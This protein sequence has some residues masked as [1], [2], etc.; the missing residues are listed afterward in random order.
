MN[1]DL[2]YIPETITVHLGSPSSSAENVTVPFAD[3]IKNVA[4]SEIYPTWPVSALRAN[5]LAQI[6]FAL[7]RVYTEYYRSRGYNFD[8]TNS[9]AYDQSYVRDREIFEN[10]GQITDE[11]FDSYIRREGYVEPLFA[12]YCNGTT[13][14]CAGMSQ[15]GSVA[16]AEQGY[17]SLD[18]LRNY[19]G[20]DIEI[21]TDA[22]VRSFYPSAPESPLRLGDTG[23][24]VRTVQLR[25]N[26][27]SSNF[28]T[29][30]KI[31]PVNGF[32][33][34]ATEQAVR[35]FQKLFSLSVDG[36]VGKATWYELE[37]VWAGVKNLNELVSE[38]VIYDDVIKQFS[39]E[40]TGGESGRGVGLLQYYLAFIAE[41]NDFVTAPPFSS[42]YDDST[43][44]S[45]SEFQHAYSLPVT[46]NTDRVTWNAIFDVYTGLADSLPSSVFSGAIKPFPGLI[47]R[48]GARGEDVT[49]LQEYLNSISAVYTEIPRVTV[50]G[51]YGAATEGAVEAFQESFGLPVTGDVN[52]ETWY[53]IGQVYGDTEGG[54]YRNAGQYPGSEVGNE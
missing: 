31:E 24:D 28:P 37:R 47:L 3:Y 52:L 15:W 16:L 14:T 27:V 36:V 1:A 44:S 41:Y 49:L 48:R 5:I 29:I 2:P 18:I 33:D 40:F 10:V 50:D 30:P 6:S 54:Q 11:I 51:V 9:T 7:N 38:G 20:D 22:P 45:V 17:N 19:Y 34:N 8:I 4:S 21:V 35:A 23:N 12:Q 39:E 25:L 43:K 26:R 32:F 46:G 13:V 42:V 53:A